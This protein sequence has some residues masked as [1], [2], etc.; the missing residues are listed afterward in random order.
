VHI[1]ENGLK[2][3]EEF[4]G[5][6]PTIYRDSVGVPTIGYGTT[7]AD[8]QPLPVH[9][10]EPEAE[11]LLKERIAH[12]YEPSV[13]NLGIPL[14]QNQYDALCSFVYNLGP[15]ILGPSHTIGQKLH[16]HDYNGAADALLLYDKAGGQA[17]AGLTRR[18]QAERH[19]FLTP[20]APVAPADPHHYDRFA[21]NVRVGPL[22]L[23]ERAI[24]QEYDHLV[25]ANQKPA[26]R[27]VLQTQIRLLRHRLKTVATST[28]PATW[29]KFYRGWR[30]QQ[31]NHRLN[32]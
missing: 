17:L 16:A 2:L 9:L 24:V 32:P 25:A 18:R 1:S 22:K 8:V 4:E 21:G 3:I 20:A 30:W 6:S 28:R 23:N 14:N 5:F 29:D 31:L 13:N 7:E 27:L 10:T 19:L 15:G 12:K 26:R 11:A